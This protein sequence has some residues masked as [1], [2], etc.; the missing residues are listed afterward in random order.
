MAALELRQSKNVSMDLKNVFSLNLPRFFACFLVRENTL[1]IQKR[2]IFSVH[3]VILILS[4][5]IL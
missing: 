1:Q 3:R 4:W 5:L 2:E